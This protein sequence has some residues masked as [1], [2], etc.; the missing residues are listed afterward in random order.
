M[1][2]GTPKKLLDVR[3]MKELGW[4]AGIGLKQGLSDV[5]KWYQM[6]QANLRN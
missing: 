6:N 1:P 2:D 3:C 5:Y 4:S